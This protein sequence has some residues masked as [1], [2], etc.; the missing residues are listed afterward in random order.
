MLNEIVL[1][2]NLA[3]KKELQ[4]KNKFFARLNSETINELISNRV[5][6]KECNVEDFPLFKNEIIRF[7]KEILNEGCG[8]FIIDGTIFK[9]FSKEELRFLHIIISKNIGRMLVQNKQ[10]EVAVEI[11]DLGKSMKNGARYH[12]T[13][14]GGSFHTDGFHIYKNPPDYVG[15]L[16]LNQAKTGGVSNFLSAYT[17]HNKF[18]KERKDLLQVLY[19]KFYMD[20]RNENKEGEKL[21]EF[22]PIFE[23][24]DEKLNFRYQREY[25][26]GG[27]NKEN[28]P[29]TKKQIEALDYLD[30]ILKEES[31]VVS[32]R[33]KVGDMMFSNNNR[34]IHDRTTFEDY[35]DENLK[36]TLV[37]SWIRQC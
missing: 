22:E 8:L 23:F 15:L 29:L 24:N 34:L 6:L 12:H 37:R 7:K 20:K 11:K 3:W 33:L 16:C 25:I 30:E 21:T 27:H 9:E 2:E 10:K 35:E 13:K 19:N 26:E 32:Y 17:I 1:D 36:R 18:F 5:K 31:F 14:E 4:K 28:Q